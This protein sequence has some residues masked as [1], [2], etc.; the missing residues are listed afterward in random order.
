MCV[1]CPDAL[2]FWS[3]L[4]YPV[5]VTTFSCASGV[6][7][8]DPLPL[9]MMFPVVL[10]NER[11]CVTADTGLPLLSLPRM[12]TFLVA[13]MRLTS[14]K[15]SLALS[16]ARSFWFSFFALADWFRMILSSPSQVKE[17]LGCLMRMFPW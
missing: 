7:I 17:Y 8:L 4:R 14:S 12:M 2:R 11:V 15:S 10:L 9:S 13:M 5:L 6:V 3:S 1:P 16:L